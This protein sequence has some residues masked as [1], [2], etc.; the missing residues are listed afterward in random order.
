LSNSKSG[1]S[2]GVLVGIRRSPPTVP[3]WFDPLGLS[4]LDALPQFLMAPALHWR[5]VSQAFVRGVYGVKGR[6]VQSIGVIFF[7]KSMELQSNIIAKSF[8][9]FG[10]GVGK[11][12]D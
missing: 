11:V 3:A 12:L 4:E 2:K 10:K 6:R 1:T 9:L 5:G 8:I 7:A